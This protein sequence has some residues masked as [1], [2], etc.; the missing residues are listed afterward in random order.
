MIKVQEQNQPQVEQISIQRVAD[1]P[2]VQDLQQSRT[3]CNL[4]HQNTPESPPGKI[5]PEH[6][7]TDRY[8]LNHWQ[9]QNSP[10][11]PSLIGLDC[12]IGPRFILVQFRTPHHC[13]NLEDLKIK[14]FSKAPWWVSPSLKLW[15][16]GWQLS[17]KQ[18]KAGMSSL[19]M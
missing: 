18:F 3:W 15:S 12:M 19:E 8:I 17:P 2:L 10:E 7:K 5:V 16:P 11:S 9:H 6:D 4:Q 13:H 1:P 14:T